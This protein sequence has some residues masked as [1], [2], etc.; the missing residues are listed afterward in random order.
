MAGESAIDQ[1]VRHYNAYLGLDKADY[2]KWR[3]IRRYWSRVSPR[4]KAEA[5]RLEEKS[6]KGLRDQLAELAKQPSSLYMRVKRDDTDS[7]LF[8]PIGISVIKPREKG[9]S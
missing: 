5:R 8:A 2:A 9:Y 6:E 4:L 1:I 7:G 3:L